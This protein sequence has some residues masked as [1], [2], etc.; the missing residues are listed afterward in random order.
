MGRSCLHSAGCAEHHRSRLVFARSMLGLATGSKVHRARF[1]TS[2][3]TLSVASALNCTYGMV[4]LTDT[5][6]GLEQVMV[7]P[8]SLVLAVIILVNSLDQCMEPCKP[9]SLLIGL[10]YAMQNYQDTCLINTVSVHILFIV[11]E[12]HAL[13]RQRLICRGFNLTGR[14]VCCHAWMQQ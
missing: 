4:S 2:E 1:D 9:Y 3:H 8:T 5:L 10:Q 6:G 7:G 14:K 13:C 11:W 12:Y